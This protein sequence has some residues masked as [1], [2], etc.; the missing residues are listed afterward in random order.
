MEDVGISRA[1]LSLVKFFEIV[2]VG[3]AAVVV[4]AAAW[5]VVGEFGVGLV[6]MGLR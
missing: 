5:W 3:A 6:R 2:M 1:T 4:V